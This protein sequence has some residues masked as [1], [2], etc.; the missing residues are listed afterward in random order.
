MTLHIFKTYKCIIYN[1]LYASYGRI[2]YPRVSC[3]CNWFLIKSSLSFIVDC[4]SS[5]Q[6]FP[7]SIILIPMPELLKTTSI[8]ISRLSF[9]ILHLTI[10]PLSWILFKYY[11]LKWL[12][13]P[14]VISNSILLFC[15]QFS[16][17]WNNCKTEKNQF[18]YHFRP[19]FFEA[20]Y[21]PLIMARVRCAVWRILL[22][23]NMYTSLLIFANDWSHT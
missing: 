11:I 15:L 2:V 7:K 17:L 23:M 19:F 14:P 13:L 3:R 10:W 20:N 22:V 1:L 16:I 6:Y 12:L 8:T 18:C 5:L 4:K 9:I 21:P